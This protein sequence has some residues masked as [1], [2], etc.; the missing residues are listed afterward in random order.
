[1]T[2]TAQTVTLT[3][4]GS[5]SLTLSGVAVTGA[6]SADFVQNNNCG[7]SLAAGSNCTIVLLFTP[8][9]SGARSATLSITD[10]ATGSPKP[11]VFQ[12]PAAMT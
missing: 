5:T 1:M 6:N 10:N 12:A 7:S 2:S 4:T 8:S 3:N 11:L 9:A